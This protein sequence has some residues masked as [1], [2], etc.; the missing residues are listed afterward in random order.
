MRHRHAFLMS[1]IKGSLELWPTLVE[2]GDFQKGSKG[3]PQ[4]RVDN[5]K[6][7]ASVA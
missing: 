4:T 1:G 2:I 7:V 3:L 5:Q 6:K